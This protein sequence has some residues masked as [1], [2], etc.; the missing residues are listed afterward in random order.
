MKPFSQY[1]TESEKTFDYRIKI[2]GDVGAE[3]LTT[4]KEKLKKFDPVK[5]SAPKTTPVQSRPA[6]FPE[7]TNQR[8]TMIDCCFRYPATDPMIRQY[9]LLCGLDANMICINDLGWSEGMDQELLGIAKDG[10]SSILEKPYP[11]DSAEQKQLKKDHTDGNQQVLRNS[12]EKAVWTVAGG[13]TPP[14]VTTN[15]LPQGVESPMTKMNRPPRP[16]TGSTPQGKK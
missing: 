12:A 10:E 11:A 16:A 8:V 6:D 15:D 13:K 4:F 14:A 9:A 7:H 3:F 5:I 2:C 1:L